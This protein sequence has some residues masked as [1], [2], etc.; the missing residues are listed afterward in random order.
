MK[1]SLAEKDSLKAGS[2]FK[3]A[4]GQVSRRSEGG[5]SFGN[6][7]MLGSCSST[8]P[9]SALNKNYTNKNVFQGTRRAEREISGE[10]VDLQPSGHQF[11]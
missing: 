6:L 8:E 2:A 7:N 1:F 10:R 4:A 5:Q 11:L 9:C 3:R